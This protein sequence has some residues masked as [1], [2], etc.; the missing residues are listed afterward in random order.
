M[1]TLT[2]RQFL[3]EKLKG[4][5]VS[6]IQIERPARNARIAIHSARPGVIIGKKGGEIESLRD[7][8]ARMVNV[9]VHIYDS[10][11]P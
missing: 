11:N 10:R 1:Q 9:P 7:E 6:R 3:Q 4:A 8:L 5:S 2:I